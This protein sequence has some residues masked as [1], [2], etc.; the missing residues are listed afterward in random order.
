[1][2]DT[3]RLM[4]APPLHPDCR[5]LLFLLGRWDGEGRGLWAADPP[6]T[7]R[8]EVLIDHT[9]KPFLRYAQR[10]WATDDGR[11]MHS[12]VGYLRPL[13]GPAVELL[14]AQPTGF[15][16]IHSGPVVDGVLELE[17]QTLGV[18]PSAKPVTA[19]SR[20]I[21]VEDG[22]VLRYLL[23]L[24]MN[25]ETPADHLTAALRRVEPKTA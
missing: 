2:N 9:G 12:E 18:A 20:R 14:V 24:G 4:T 7:Y 1:M 25:R 23:R 10:T 6:F 8:E 16:E 19:V 22:S 17:C 11:P 5:P 15:V 3:S 13:P 21:W